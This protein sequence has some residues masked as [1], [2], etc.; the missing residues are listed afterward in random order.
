[1][2]TSTRVRCDLG[3]GLTLY[4]SCLH[5]LPGE[6]VVVLKL[7]GAWVVVFLECDEGDPG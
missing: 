3:N 1:M 6:E 4:Q 7:R 2:P 5:R